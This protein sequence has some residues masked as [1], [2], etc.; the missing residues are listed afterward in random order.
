MDLNG[1]IAFVRVIQAGSF[2]RAAKQMEMPLSTVS[3]KVATLEKNLGTSLIQRTTRRLRL[4]KAGEVY[5]AHAVRAVTELQTAEALTQETKTGVQGRVR[6]TAPVEIGMSSLA[7]CLSLFLAKFPEVE[8]DLILTDRVVDL[9]AE[10]VDIALRMGDLKD[11]SLISKRIGTSGSQA[12]ASPAYLKRAPA[13]RRPEDLADHSCLIFSNVFDGGWT[14]ERTNPRSVQKVKVKG[15]F[16]ANNLIA[17]HRLAAEGR[18]IAL[19]PAFLC[20]D[21]IE[22]KRLVQVLEGWATRRQPVNIV[23]PHQS[24]LPKSTRALIDH[25]AEFLNDVF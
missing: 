10:G 22:K 18:G 14:L 24:F 1:V 16:T 5:F 21:D 12:Y 17:L 15:H 7:D 23:Y 9:I 8:V 19:L 25:I 4:T 13:V 3:A 11:S 2:S 20:Q 6:L